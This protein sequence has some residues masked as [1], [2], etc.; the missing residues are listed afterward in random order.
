MACFGLV[1]QVEASTTK[2]GILRIPYLEWLFKW[3]CLEGWPWQLL[4]VPHVFYDVAASKQ[5]ANFTFCLMAVSDTCLD[6]SHSSNELFHS[7]FSTG[8]RSIQI[9]GWPESHRAI[10]WSKSSQPMDFRSFES[11]PIQ[12]L[13]ATRHWDVSTFGF[14]HLFGWDSDALPSRI[15][16][17][18]WRSRGA[19]LV[20]TGWRNE[21]RGCLL[22]YTPG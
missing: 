19:E 14:S 16:A 9:L 15:E 12:F 10:Q 3:L 7:K 18:P 4:D 6:H 13:L 22:W 11:F 2:G 20:W 5:F 8:H 1:K 21:G 17:W